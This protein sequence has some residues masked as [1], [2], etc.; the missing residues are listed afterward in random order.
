MGMPNLP[1][2][3][4]GEIFTTELPS[5]RWNAEARFRGGNGK[6]RKVRRTGKTELA[7]KNRLREACRDE[8]GPVTPSGVSGG[9]RLRKLAEIW[10]SELADSDKSDGTRRVYLSISKQLDEAL[11]NRTVSELSV[12]DIEEH[13]KEVASVK[14]SAAKLQRTVLTQQLNIAVRHG[15]L[16]ANPV[17]AVSGMKRPRR[18]PVFAPDVEEVKWVRNRVRIYFDEL[19]ANRTFGPRKDR[20]LIDVIDVCAFTG[21]R[22]GEVLALLWEDID[23][24]NRLLSIRGTIS[25]PRRQPYGKSG[26]LDFGRS[27]TMSDALVNLLLERKVR[28]GV[29]AHDA[30]FASRTG[31]FYTTGALHKKM[32]RFREAVGFR[33]D[34]TFHSMR[35]TIAT[36]LALAD[37]AHT[38]ASQLGHSHENIAEKFYIMRPK[39]APD[40]S[41]IIQAAYGESAP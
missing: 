9:T 5:G 20:V 12:A 8:A 10:K 19:D 29:N 34:F 31:N 4:H 15:A 2:G 27:L 26:A 21:A 32:A 40:S 22:I 37:S 33:D 35:K 11:G 16:Q 14:P 6:T 25:G 39:L 30:V 23:F 7:A 13:L 3:S 17:R 18:Q 24:E 36:L 41:A 38:A 1:I 28:V